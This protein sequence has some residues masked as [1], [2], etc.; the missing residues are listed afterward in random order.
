MEK[1][2]SLRKGS[3]VVVGSCDDVGMHS[4]TL[5]DVKSQDNVK[6]QESG[7]VSVFAGLFGNH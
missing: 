6:S 1:E 4:A 2:V 7:E 3:T 5:T